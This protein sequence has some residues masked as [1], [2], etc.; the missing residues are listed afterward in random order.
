MINSIL[1]SCGESDSSDI[2]KEDIVQPQSFSGTSSDSENDVLQASRVST[3]SG[4]DGT[5]WKP[6]TR[7]NHVVAQNIVRK[8]AGQQHIQPKELQRYQLLHSI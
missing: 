1:Q 4:R 5:Q 8:E 7:N 6:Y 2:G 3:L